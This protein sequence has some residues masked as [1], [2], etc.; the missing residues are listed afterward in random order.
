MSS[1][2][3]RSFLGAAL[4]GLALPAWFPRL[5]FAAPA[6]AQAA[7]GRDVLV[8]V[9]LRGGV[10][11]ISMVVPVGDADYYHHRRALAIAEPGNTSGAALDLDGF[12]AFHPSL[13]PLLDLW[14]DGV[15][16]AVH[17]VGNPE[18][19]HS[20]FDAMDCWERGTPGNKSTSTGWL[21]RHLATVS[22]ANK[23]PFRGIGIGA[24]VQSS[25]RGPIPATAL[26]SIA[27][28]HLRGNGDELA[29]FQQSMASLYSGGGLLAVQSKQTL[30]AVAKLATLPAD[31]QPANGASYP[32]S[33]LG[34]AL[35]QVARI[36]KADLG[37]EVACVDAGGFDTHEEEGNATGELA[38]LLA[39]L[40]AALA[41]FYADMLERMGRTTVV[42][43][44]EFGRRVFE[45]A[46][47]G[48]DHGRAGSMLLLGGGIHGGR[49]YG[50]WPGLHHEALL[51]PGDLAL[52]SD[53]RTVL[54]EIVDRRLGNKRLGEV[55]PGFRVPAYLGVTV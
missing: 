43:M 49:V 8:C 40:G 4:G 9:F 6:E 12:F 37:L 41:A 17:A 47:R 7:S 25:L 38:D 16:A 3:R 54:A 33:P 24:V 34:Q 19:T 51:H 18:D 32:G 44:S 53:F 46:S 5:A 36:A 26:R 21:G 35:L 14:N 13:A 11:A 30:A 23:S 22:N 27:D 15:L 28:F 50:E 42:V 39:D 52:T 31:Y 2:S 10:D 20:H 29:R 48:T 1:M 55:F 45:N